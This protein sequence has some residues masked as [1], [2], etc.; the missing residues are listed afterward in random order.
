MQLSRQVFF[1]IAAGACLAAVVLPF[2]LG[3]TWLERESASRNNGLEMRLRDLKREGD[4]LRLT[5]VLEWVG[6]K[7]GPFWPYGNLQVRFWDFREYPIEAGSEV[8]YCVPH[9]FEYYEPI[10]LSLKGLLRYVRGEA[11]KG[12][13]QAGGCVLI[14]AG[15]AFVT[16]EMATPVI[17]RKFATRK[18]WLPAFATS[19]RSKAAAGEK[20]PSRP[21]RV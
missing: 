11:S 5:Y 7:D 15:A 17:D 3:Q 8:P 9:D 10:P 14:P 18:L 12:R 2:V 16:L 21:G 4:T 19:V 6:K 1:V 13:Y 20:T